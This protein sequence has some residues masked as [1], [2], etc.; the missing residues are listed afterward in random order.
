MPRVD[1]PSIKLLAA[2]YTI[3]IFF[4]DPHGHKLPH[5]PQRNQACAIH[6]TFKMSHALIDDLPPLKAD[7]QAQQEEIHAMPD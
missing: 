2:S 1:L 5:R 4:P 3:C 6:Q 7:Q